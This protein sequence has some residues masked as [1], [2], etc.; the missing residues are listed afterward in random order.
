MRSGQE[1]AGLC[2]RY[3]LVSDGET[4]VAAFGVHELAALTPR[5]NIAPSQLVPTLA[6]NNGSIVFTNL[7]WG[8]VPPWA[9]DRKMGSRLINARAET[10]A[11]K[12]SFRTA[13]QRRRCLI[14]ADGYYEWVKQGDIKQPYYIFQPSRRPFAFAGL[15]EAWTDKQGPPYLSCSIITCAS[16]ADLGSIHH[17]MPVA[18]DSSDYRRWLGDQLHSEELIE[19][20]KPAANGTFSA[21]PVSTFV[22]SPAHEGPDCVTPQNH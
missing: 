15:W 16:N 22:N 7:H 1:L 21:L 6:Q 13:F 14:L 11:E 12:P 20:L 4:L 19:L 5:Y 8:L 18:L 10:V 2:G 3:T 9:K 17:R